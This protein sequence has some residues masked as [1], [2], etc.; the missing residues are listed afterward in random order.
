MRSTLAQPMSLQGA[1]VLFLSSSSRSLSFLIVIYPILTTTIKYSLLVLFMAYLVIGTLYNHFALNLRGGDQIPKFNL[2]FLY[3][4]MQWAIETSVHAIESLFTKTRSSGQTLN[5]YSHQ[6]SAT[7]PPPVR[8]PQ[9]AANPVRGG[10]PHRA[11]T[12]EEEE[13]MLGGPDDFSDDAEDAVVVGDVV[14]PPQ[15]QA[16]APQS[17]P[18]Q[19]NPANMPTP[20]PPQQSSNAPVTTT[21]AAPQSVSAPVPAPA[22]QDQTTT[23]TVP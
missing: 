17:L 14:Q 11:F 12:L 16:P 3:A 22:A 7:G 23:K 15:V 1:W 21:P 19:Q 10:D 18:Q 5:S 9:R 4:S 8:T 13:A 20:V 2:P 6:W